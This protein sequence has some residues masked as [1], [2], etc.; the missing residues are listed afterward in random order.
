MRP[1]AI[2]AAVPA[3]PPPTTSTSGS[4]KI[5]NIARGFVEGFGRTGTPGTSF[6]PSVK[7]SMPCSAPIA[8]VRLSSLMTGLS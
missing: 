1:A 5:G 6:G 4:A 7:N 3:G 2:A 8:L